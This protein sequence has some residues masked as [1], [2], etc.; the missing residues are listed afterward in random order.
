MSTA[1][2]LPTSPVA[3][4]S[5]AIVCLLAPS[6]KAYAQAQDR[7]QESV[8]EAR[9]ELEIRELRLKL[10]VQSEYP[11]ERQRLTSAI[12]L[13]AAAAHIHARELA[14]FEKLQR[15]SVG[16]PFRVTVDEARY[17]ELAARTRE[18]DLKEELRILD[19]NFRS[20][21]RLLE[22]EV[23]AARARLGPSA[24][25]VDVRQPQPPPVIAPPRYV[26]YAVGRLR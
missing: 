6:S 11:L 7:P 24:A 14:D 13:S 2:L 19:R 1:R 10:Y 5:M 8:D 22:L 16:E 26:K 3:V 4:F 20:R 9:R 12:K 18:A 25:T 23:E 21:R 17:A 15:F